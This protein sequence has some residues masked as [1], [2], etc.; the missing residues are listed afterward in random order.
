MGINTD[1]NATYLWLM[2]EGL[3]KCGS[4]LDVLSLP[5]KSNEPTKVEVFKQN[6]DY[7]WDIP[8]TVI[9]QGKYHLC[10]FSES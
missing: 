1:S 2:G 6:W 3:P 10:L 7:D 9:S 5:M 8:N 4:K